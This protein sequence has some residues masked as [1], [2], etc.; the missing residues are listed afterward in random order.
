M[1]KNKIRRWMVACKEHD[2]DVALMY[3]DGADYDLEEAVQRYKD[4]EEWE[5]NNP[6]HKGK[7]K[8]P[9][10]QNKKQIK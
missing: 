6:M 5:R 7:G 3:L 4:D 1:R 9:K 8:S 2:Y 10:K